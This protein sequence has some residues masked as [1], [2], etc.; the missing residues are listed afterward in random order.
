M[1]PSPPPDRSLLSGGRDQRQ[2]L[3]A[4]V[5]GGALAGLLGLGYAAWLDY[6]GRR[7]SK[8][9]GQTCCVPGAQ[10]RRAPGSAIPAALHLGDAAA[11]RGLYVSVC[12]G[13]HDDDG[14]GRRSVGDHGSLRDL[15][16]LSLAPAAVAT[17]IV[18][19]AGEMP[20]FGGLLD[21]QEV[22]DLVAH[23]KSMETTSHE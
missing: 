19:G 5:G 3:G 17:V 12:A 10:P 8:D 15:R 20:A 9:T 1:L 23:V 14:S 11:G 2:R 22:R 13:C 7:P 21:A 6:R 4:A 18:R 16:Q